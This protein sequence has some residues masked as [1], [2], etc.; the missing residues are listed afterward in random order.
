[1]TIAAF[2]FAAI[3]AYYWGWV[4]A[5]QAVATECRRLGG[6]YVGKTT[7]KCVAVVEPEPKPVSYTP[8]PRPPS[9]DSA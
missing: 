1:M 9:K 3:A 4:R 2:A 5:H 7:Y 8:S 6:F